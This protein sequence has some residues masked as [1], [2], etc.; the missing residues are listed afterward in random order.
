MA[1]Q[2]FLQSGNLQV[3]VLSATDEKQD[4]GPTLDSQVKVPLVTNGHSISVIDE[5]CGQ[6]F[7]AKWNPANG[8]RF[9]ATG[10]AG[11]Y[12]VDIWDFDTIRNY[13]LKCKWLLIVCAAKDE[14][15]YPRVADFA[16]SVGR[17]K[18]TNPLS[19]R[20]GPPGSHALL[21]QG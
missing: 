1:L 6:V 10:G 20:G 16:Q 4:R 18:Y 3:S 14:K 5:H 21:G 11:D 2:R 19:A 7:F 12:F 8:R 15:R 9:C 17:M 13:D